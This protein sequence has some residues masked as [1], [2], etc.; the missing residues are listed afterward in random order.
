M[1]TGV[2]AEMTSDRAAVV[3]ADGR[4]LTY[5]GLER[6]S[7][8]L[9]HWFRSIGLRRGDHIAFVLENRPEFFVVMWAAQRAGLY[10]TPCSTRLGTAELEHIVNDCGAEVLIASDRTLTAVGA[11][12][13]PA[14]RHRLLVGDARA[15]GWDA[16]GSAIAAEPGTPIADQSEGSF[17]LYSSG[18]T[19]LPKGVKQPLPD[20][21]FL[22]PARE[23]AQL[24]GASA[25]TVF[26]SPAPLYHAAPLLFALMIHRVGGCIV[27]EERFDPTEFLELVER[28]R[29]TM[30]QVV[31]TM[32]IRL[33]G[34]PDDVRGRADV[35]S[36]ELVVHAAAPCPIEVKERM[37]AW[38]GPV[39]HE[40]YSA[41]E[42][43]G[44][45]YCDSESWLAHKGTVGQSLLGPVHILDDEGDELP[46]GTPGTIYFEN[47]RFEYLG[48]PDK[49]RGAQDPRGR[50]WST[51]GDIGYL[52]D[53]GF[54]FLTDR[55]SYV[56]ISGG[57]NIYP[58]EAEN[59]LAVHP[60]VADVAVFGVPDDEMGESV[61]AVIELAAGVTPSAEVEAELLQF[62]RDRLAAYK[63]PRTVDF[64]DELPRHETGKLYKRLL[65]DE[66]WSGR[67][68]TA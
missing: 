2:L 6:A 50:G 23:F 55:R 18:T 35:S 39:I 65:K 47:S 31:P 30:T 58:Q 40:Y 41:T 43:I 16:L 38:L 60:K 49:T 56:I 42:G 3:M 48:D 26:L 37:I 27:V 45:V 57:V 34:L 29:V 25:E 15:E 17:L 10:Y 63:C 12:A 24:F 4:V 68:L 61:H 59:T 67:T 9:A 8:Q 19:G 21:P 54:L 51:V 62:C 32:F 5:G 36:L 46:A 1:S 64:R 14:V 7:N 52:D 20:E 33:L 22:Q 53:D 11:V 28:H 66:Y 44:F 13:A